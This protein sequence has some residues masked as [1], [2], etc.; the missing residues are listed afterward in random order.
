[1]TFSMGPSDA[2]VEWL[3]RRA[4]ELAQTRLALDESAELHSRVAEL[5]QN[6]RDL[7]QSLSWRITGPVRWLGENFQ[8]RS[9]ATICE[10]VEPGGPSA[11]AVS[12][13]GLTTRLFAEDDPP[14]FAV[15]PQRIGVDVTSLCA[16]DAGGGIQRVVRQ[17]VR[18]L[19]ALAPDDVVL[20]DLRP[21]WPSDAT[22]RF[23]ENETT[24]A[25]A[26]RPCLDFRSIF[27]LDASWRFVDVIGP[28]MTSARGA[29]IEIV[30]CVYDLIPVDCPETCLP[31]TR[32]AFVRWLAAAVGWCDRFV[33]ISEAVACR[34][35]EHLAGVADTPCRAIG[36][37]PLGCD[38][39]EPSGCP[40]APPVA[41]AYVLMVGT[42]EPRKAHATALDAFEQGW[43]SGEFA[44]S[45]VVAGR[46]GWGTDDF[47]ARMTSHPEWRRKLFWFDGPDDQTLNAL[48]QNA[49]AILQPST[50]EGFGLPI[51]EGGR[52]GKPIVM[53]DL[54][55]FRELVVE[56]GYFFAA[57]DRAGL[58]AALRR[59]LQ[60]GAPTTSVLQTSWNTSSSKLLSWLRQTS[61]QTSTR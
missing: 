16:S 22:W 50:A 52:F 46:P 48:Y 53:S 45:L 18:H 21:G 10:A 15:H 32:E 37:W 28:M 23:F 12:R 44:A 57:G 11:P 36:W 27:L 9:S 25:R 49:S 2:R 5:E 40:S 55:V 6:M 33:C 14:P 17:I 24:L 54:P 60:P 20:L 56:H 13:T 4:A 31:Q 39:I 43:A 59:A 1:M 26:N 29:G 3:Q 7:K 38:F 51:V 8:H 61:F 41:G 42:L 30:G 58:G 47:V 34:L 19:V 35:Q